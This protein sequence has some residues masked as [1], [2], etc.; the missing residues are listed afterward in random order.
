MAGQ[1]DLTRRGVLSGAAAL[2]ASAGLEPLISRSA[3]AASRKPA[4]RPAETVP[5][6]GPHQAGIATAA[7]DYLHFAA[8][9]MR[10]AGAAELKGL[11][12]RWTAVAEKL[13]VGEAYE[14]SPSQA[15][16]A[17]QETGEALGLGPSR[18]TLTFGFG[19]SLFVSSS[20]GDRFGLRHSRPAELRPLPAFAGDRLDPASSGGDLC[21]QACADDPQVA[22]HAIHMLTR[23]AAGTAALRWAQ[24]GFGRT[25]STTRAQRTPRNLMGFKDG[26][27]NVRG[28][29]TAA[30]ED[31]VWARRGDG[32]RWMAGG[33]YLISR[34]I[35]MLFDSW[36]ATSLESQQRT[37]G[38]E[39]R[40]GAPLGARRE[41]DPVDLLATRSDGQPVIPADAHIRLSSPKTNQG[42]EI[43]RRGYSYGA[44]VEAGSGEIDAGLF[45]IAFQRSPR[46]QFIPIQRRLAA[47]DALS[48]FTAHTSSAIFAC[49]PGILPGGF[50]G[51]LLFA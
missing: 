11:L 30:L 7:Q 24:Q 45:F 26:T 3:R 44:G 37:V 19:P 32:P 28:E 29:D 8:F 43:L 22:F 25:S 14:P 20:R 23:A 42:A 17:P 48:R 35:R 12:E 51:E 34:R 15:A 4:P 18:L 16:R 5:F 27:N 41:H 40:S 1:G 38:R 47:S 10:A 46:R 50:V 6:H 33:T 31:F 13:T 36:D 9:D 49:P 2:A 39:K 21:V